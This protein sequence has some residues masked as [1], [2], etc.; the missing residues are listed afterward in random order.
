MTAE[1]PGRIEDYAL[2]GDCLTAALVSRTGSID[3]LC[4]PRFDG[5]ACFAALLGSSRH[6]RWKIAPADEGTV[7]RAYRDGTMV[8]ETRFRGAAGE[9]VL[10]EFMPMGRETSSIVRIARGLRGAVRMHMEL[11]LRFDF[12]KTVPW[13][14][15]RDDRTGIT[16]I[17]GPD[18]VVLRGG[19]PLHGRDFTTLADFT[20]SEGEEVVFCL[21]HGPSHLAEPAPFDPHAALAETE[22]EWRRF[23][24][25]STVT[26]PWKALV[27][28]SLLT[29]R[30]LTYRPTGG[31]VAAVTTSLP[32]RI[33]GARNWDY[34]YCWLRD[35]TL[36]LFA[37]MRAGYTDEAVAWRDWLQRSVA[38]SPAQI[39]IMYG[40]Q[41]ERRLDE[42]EVPWLPGYAGSKPV[43]VGNAAAGQVQL[44]VYGEMLEC[45]HQARRH[46]LKAAGHGWAMQ[47]GVLDHLAR[48]WTE[49]DEGMWEVR[50]GP[51]HFTFS[52]VMC[53]VAVD[54]MIRDVEEFGLHGDVAS[55]RKL[56]DEIRAEVLRRGVDPRRGCF[57][58]T[59]GG[60][61][62]DASLLLIPIVGFLPVE[63][64]RVAATVRAVEKDLLVDGFVR[65]YR[66]SG[67]VDGLQ[68]E[69]GVFLACSFWLV[70]VY[71]LQGRRAEAEALFGRLA[72]LCN[73]VGLLS[74]EYDPAARR[75]VGNF[76][77][78][79]SHVA[80]VLSAMQM[81]EHGAAPAGE[82]VQGDGEDVQAA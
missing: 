52:K 50:G 41:G 17:A 72:A 51:Q 61:E 14:T 30:A 45:L 29:L 9:A 10:T 70:D 47:R 63:D 66:N 27:D 42:W 73:D 59:F 2:I 80:L 78:A 1:T 5:A 39:Q 65:R 6:G 77:Q 43:R 62:L 36:T 46:G 60:R 35:A 57:V 69:E 82:N 31:I 3:W 12:G 79:F 25:R 75:Q 26:G 20:L 58:Q 22:A 81:A 44:D 8:L 21:S 67:G 33:G 40:L 48:I 13:V 49:P 55:W 11:A 23:A 68:G 56:R 54:R 53:W 64:E 28:R 4:L 76:P 7:S 16:A 18:M 15:R 37:L 32:E 71:L 19:V 74:E 24:G 34:R 38:G